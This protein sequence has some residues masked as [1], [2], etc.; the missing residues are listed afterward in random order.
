MSP[1]LC[2]P[3][4]RRCKLR[5]QEGGGRCKSE[6][7]D[8][9]TEGRSLQAI[10][11]QESF[12]R[13]LDWNYH[14]MGTRA[15]RIPKYREKWEEEGDGCRETNTQGISTEVTLPPSHGSQE[16]ARTQKERSWWEMKI[17]QGWATCSGRNHSEVVSMET[18]D[19]GGKQ[20]NGEGKNECK[21][22]T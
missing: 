16:T 13:A 7:M 21:R 2:S 6:E 11:G 5:P 20:V 12:K 9:R 1:N 3:H 18:D 14:L 17:K 10:D 15:Q 22:D 4:E 8:W 19:A